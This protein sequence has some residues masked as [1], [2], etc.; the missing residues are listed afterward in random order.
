MYQA[1]NY[2]G[3]IRFS[4][5]YATQLYQNGLPLT[6]AA[7]GGAV[8]LSSIPDLPADRIKSGIFCVGDHACDILPTSNS[9][10]NLGS[11][12]NQWNNVF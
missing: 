10:F 8:S 2:N 12:S 4:K 7:T 9:A 5:V 3:Q 1:R 6:A 11:S